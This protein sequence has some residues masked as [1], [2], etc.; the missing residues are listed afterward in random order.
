[1][2][3][4]INY[5][6][7]DCFSIPLREGGFGRGVIVRMD[8]EGIVFSYFYGPLIEDANDLKIDSTITPGREVLVG[9]FGDLG[10]LNNEWEIIGHLKNWKSSE[11]DLP[12]FLRWEE[13]EDT[14]VICAYDD[15]LEL[16]SEE[17][18]LISDHDVSRIP[19]DRLM[20]Y[21]S[22]EIKLT[23]ILIN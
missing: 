13:G 20:G 5:S 15:T 10:L 6:I 7:G 17:S 3:K 2:S 8:G 11:W 18:V 9:Q 1:M 19:E 12:K 4:N 14:G 22:V 21:G 16:I 23:K